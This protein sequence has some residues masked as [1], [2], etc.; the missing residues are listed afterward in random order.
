[1]AEQIKIEKPKKVSKSKS[2]AKAKNQE[3]DLRTPSGKPMR[4]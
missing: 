4:F 2:A 3:Q 1:M